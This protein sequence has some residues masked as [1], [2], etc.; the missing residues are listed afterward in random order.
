MPEV[1][2]ILAE[3]NMYTRSKEKSFYFEKFIT[4]WET[5]SE[6]DYREL[7]SNIDLLKP[8]YG[9]QYTIIR[10]ISTPAV[11]LLD[12]IKDKIAARKAEE[13]EKRRI[14]SERA[15]LAAEKRKKK[16]EAEERKLLKQ[17]QSKYGED[18]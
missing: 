7:C 3:K 16:Q 11:E 18:K 9:Y 1:A 15:K 8:P 4:D 2:V 5:I 10:R 12:S 14:K 17:L 13:E 6:E